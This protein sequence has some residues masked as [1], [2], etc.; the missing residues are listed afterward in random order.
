MDISCKIF[1]TFTNNCN[2]NYIAIPTIVC[3]TP[4]G[5]HQQHTQLQ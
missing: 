3:T 5:N 1:F 4:S 2:N